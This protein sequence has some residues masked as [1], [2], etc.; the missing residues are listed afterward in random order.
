MDPFC[1]SLVVFRFELPPS[2]DIGF[3]LE[4]QH[5][6]ACVPSILGELSKC[7]AISNV[8]CF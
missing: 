7:L 3:F 2:A 5:A 8:K 6:E 4:V 1:I